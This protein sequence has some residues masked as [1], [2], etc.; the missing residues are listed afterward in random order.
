ML[1]ITRWIPDDY[2]SIVKNLF[3]VSTVLSAVYVASYLVINKSVKPQP[4]LVASCFFIYACHAAAIPIAPLKIINKVFHFVIPC[5]TYLER[6][7]CYLVVPC[8]TAAA[9]VFAYWL[10]MKYFPKVGKIFCGGR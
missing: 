4:Q 8:V 7:F 3:Y 10:L 1:S 6:I 5:D 9:L 2:K